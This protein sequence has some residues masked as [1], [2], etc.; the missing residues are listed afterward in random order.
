VAGASVLG[1]VLTEIYLCGVLFLSRNIE[2]T[3]R[4]RPAHNGS[5]WQAAEPPGLSADDERHGGAAGRL[6]PPPVTDV[7][8][9]LRAKASQ[10]GVAHVTAR[11]TPQRATRHSAALAQ[12]V[13]LD[14]RSQLGS[15]HLVPNPRAWCC[16]MQLQQADALAWGGAAHVRYVVGGRV[17][18]CHGLQ[19]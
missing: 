19:S 15:C 11:C 16:G 9:A 8:G 4:P 10:V 2:E 7:A 12:R 3:Q 6:A 13:A 5:A 18:V 14:L 17:T 1:A